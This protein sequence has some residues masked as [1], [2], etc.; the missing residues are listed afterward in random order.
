MAA[1]NLKM[2][3]CFVLRIILG[4]V[5]KQKSKLLQTFFSDRLDIGQADIHVNIA[6]KLDQTIF[7]ENQS[8]FA[9]FNSRKC[10][11][12]EKQ[13]CLHVAR[14]SRSEA[15]TANKIETKCEGRLNA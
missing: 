6:T 12:R 13:S 2:E 3:S 7:D 11:Q 8:P 5:K 14:T 15:F 10:R 4:F 1:Y 9:V